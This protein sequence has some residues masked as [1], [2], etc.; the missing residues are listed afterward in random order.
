MPYNALQQSEIRFQSTL[1]L[2][3]WFSTTIRMAECGS[4]APFVRPS[5]VFK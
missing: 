1:L 5:G 3:K 2:Y 4:Q